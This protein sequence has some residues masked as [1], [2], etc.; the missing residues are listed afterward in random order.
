MKQLLPVALAAIA[1]G[2]STSAPAEDLFPGQAAGFV[3]RFCETLVPAVAVYDPNASGA[4]P[5]DDPA[6]F[7]PLVAA[8]L[9]AMI[10][11]ALA[12]N[13][14]FENET[15]GK[16]LLGDGVPWT[17]VQD[18]ASDCTAGAIVETSASA[19]VAVRYSYADAPGEGWS[20]KLILT[21]D[22]EKWHL[23]DIRYGEDGRTSL[24]AVLAQALEQ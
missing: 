10:E 22:G 12:H 23:E 20:D 9:A 1:L 11:N 14:A 13:A 2:H 7:G 24:R 21:Q 5:P 18:A 19:E 15:G 17:S 4:W 16:G 8:D 6:V 3:D